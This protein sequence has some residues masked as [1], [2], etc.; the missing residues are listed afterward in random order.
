MDL[1]CIAEELRPFARRQV[2]LD[3]DRRIVR[4]LL[5]L[6]T[7]WRPTLGRSGA[8]VEFPAG[9]PRGLRLYR[10]PEVRETAALL[11]IHGGGYII[12]HPRQDDGHCAT[13]ATELGILVVSPR[14]RLAPEH[15]YPAALDDCHAAWKWLQAEA[16][17]LGIDPARIAIG[18]QSAGG[19]LAAALVQRIHDAGGIQPIAQWLFCP[20]LDDRT[21]A[22]RN[23]D[24]Q[25][26][27]VWNN[28]GNR[29]GWAAYLGREPGST[30][31]SPYAAPG[32]RTNFAGLP[33][34][35]IGVGD[36]DLFHDEDRAYAQ[37]LRDGG[38]A[39]ELVEVAGAPH[40]FE[41]WAPT[42]NLAQR[43]LTEARAW[44]ARRLLSGQP[45]T[46]PGSHD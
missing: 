41:T 24:T 27:L 25:G 19:G 2:A 32:R 16:A 8:R 21:A 9:A 11:W 10:P 1:S 28:T 26:H 44:L 18:G 40:A 30:Q 33:P 13:T 3:F 42:T 37:R 23:R 34:A 7:R 15:P 6:V 29:Y 14:Y 12:G 43:Y 20:M 31:V 36:V 38:V 4:F 39:V 45:G 22:Q 5:R 35:W 17:R 46:G